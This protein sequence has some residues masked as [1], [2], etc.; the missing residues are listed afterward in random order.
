MEG[1]RHHGSEAALDSV[2]SLGLGDFSLPPA[3]TRQ[4]MSLSLA[5]SPH[6]YNGKSDLYDGENDY[7]SKRV[8]VSSP[9]QTQ[10]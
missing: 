2:S 1:E 6:L 3:L 8:Q 9:Q 4:L 10:F 7:N 5:A